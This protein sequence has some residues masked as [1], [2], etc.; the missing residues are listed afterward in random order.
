M[1]QIG[2]LIGGNRDK[3]G[4]GSGSGSFSDV[5]N[6]FKEKEPPK[7]NGPVMCCHALKTSCEACKRRISV[8]QYCAKFPESRYWTAARASKAMTKKAK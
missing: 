4:S 2:S 8:E 5:A 3:G 1:I 7:L 6:D